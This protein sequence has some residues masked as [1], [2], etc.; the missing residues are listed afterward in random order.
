MPSHPGLPNGHAVIQNMHGRFDAVL[1]DPTQRGWLKAGGDTRVMTPGQQG[2]Q[3]IQPS[4]EG[5][6]LVRFRNAAGPRDPGRRVRLLAVT[7]D[8]PTL[9][10][11][12]FPCI[13]PSL[14]RGLVK[15]PSELFEVACI[16]RAPTHLDDEQLTT[17]GVH[18][19]P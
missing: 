1:A 5:P 18:G 13:P 15:E 9:G 11:L 17:G 14:T 7:L 2:R 12:V 10:P 6:G 4:L 19:K 3:K 8:G 16:N